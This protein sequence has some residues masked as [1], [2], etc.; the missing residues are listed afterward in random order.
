MEKTTNISD[1]EWKVLETLWRAPG[2]LIGEIRDALKDSGWSYSTIKTLVTRLTQKG[3]ARY[4]ETPKGREYY[5]AVSEEDTRR[6][7]T[8]G[9]IDRVYNGSVRMMFSNLVRDSKLSDAETAE[10]LELIDKM[11]D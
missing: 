5:A 3:A 10:L 11:D 9:L 8:R 6:A 2:M 7:E 1:A 4:E